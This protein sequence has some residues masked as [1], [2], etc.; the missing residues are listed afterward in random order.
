[1]AFAGCYKLA[2]INY[3]GTEEQWNNITK[4][5]NWAPIGASLEIVY[6]YTLPFKYATPFTIDRQG[7]QITEYTGDEC[8]HLEIPYTNGNT[9]VIAIASNIILDPEKQAKL[10]TVTLPNTLLAIEKDAFANC[11][12]LAYN[13][14]DNAYYL[15]TSDNPYY[16]LI[17]AVDTNITS[18]I[19]HNDTQIIAHDAF[20]GCNNLTYNTYGSA[21]YLGSTSNTYFTLIK[22]DIGTDEIEGHTKI[23]ADNAFAGHQYRKQIVIPDSVVLIGKRAFAESVLQNITFAG[24]IKYIG[25]EAFQECALNGFALPQNTYYYSND[26]VDRITYKAPDLAKYK[27]KSLIDNKES[28]FPAFY[29]GLPTYVGSQLPINTKEP[30]QQHRLPKF[31]VLEDGSQYVSAAQ[32]KTLGVGTLKASD[33]EV[34]VAT[35]LHPTET[36]IY[37]LGSS[38]YK[39]NDIWCTQASLNSTSDSNDKNSIEALPQE[40]N[41]LFDELKPVRYK[42]NKNE[43]NRYHTG[44]IAQDVQAGLEKANIPTSDFAGYLEYEKED[45]SKGYGLRYGEFIALCIDQI[46]K[47][48]ARVEEL[49]NKLDSEVK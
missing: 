12:N 41:I 9:L 11:T 19:I 23:I 29:A 28:C 38:L 32:I 25:P 45:G 17:A 1:M 20:S 27:F 16:A 2:K 44:L 21:K 13:Q 48:K 30:S 42:L 4:G 3:T 37:S 47:L 5:E 33:S 31:M 24:N 40:Y 22:S 49:E 10:C 6:N 39:W 36:G 35:S 14:Y 8:E 7:I 43:S 26:A 46:Q 15:G 34:K 18:C